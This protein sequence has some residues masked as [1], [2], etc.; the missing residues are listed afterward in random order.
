LPAGAKVVFYTDGLIERPD[1]D[2][3]VSLGILSDLAE[4]H[5]H[6]PLDA[7]VQALADHHPGD[8]RD[9]MAVLALCIPEVEKPRGTEPA[10]AR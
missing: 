9:D 3:D 6:L 10:P 1:R 8:G 2:L 4:A 5:R 7:F